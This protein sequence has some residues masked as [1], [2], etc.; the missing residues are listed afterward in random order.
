M[1]K[2]KYFRKFNMAAAIYVRL[3]EKY[4]REKWLKN[5]VARF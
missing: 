1:C 2:K 3:A 4:W 5:P